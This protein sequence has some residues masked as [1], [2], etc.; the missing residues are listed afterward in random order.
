M[1]V[2]EQKRNGVRH[3]MGESEASSA[4][5]ATA[6]IHGDRGFEA[7]PNGGYRQSRGRRLSGR[8]CWYL[9]TVGQ[10]RMLLALLLAMR[11]W[12]YCSLLYWYLGSCRAETCTLWA[13]WSY[14]WELDVSGA[15]LTK[16]SLES[17]GTHA[18]CLHCISSTPTAFSPVGTRSFPSLHSTARFLRGGGTDVCARV[19]SVIRAQS[20]L[21]NVERAGRATKNSNAGAAATVEQLIR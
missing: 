19:R 2:R 18:A 20:F 14:A 17:G 8:W 11:A 4:H 3:L 12:S 13:C 9:C 1:Q 21:I 7:P 5:I 15:R 6:Y 16:S 10:V